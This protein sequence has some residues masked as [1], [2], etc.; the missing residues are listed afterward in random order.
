MSAGT[1]KRKIFKIAIAACAATVLGAGYALDSTRHFLNGTIGERDGALRLES[2]LG[3]G[4]RAQLWLPATN[5][6]PEEDVP[7]SDESARAPAQKM[8]VLVVD[9]D[10][11]IAM[12]T[13]HMLEDLGFEVV[14]ANSGSRALEI[15][16]NSRAIDLLITD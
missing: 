7:K 14:E 1:Y 15:I 10:A 12:S 13:V 5:L 9:D 6:A 2:E 16:E 11:L 8:T 3:R 4:T